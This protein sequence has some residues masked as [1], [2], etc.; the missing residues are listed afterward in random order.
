MT[1]RFQLG[2]VLRQHE[3][4]DGVRQDTHVFGILK[5]EFYRRYKTIFR[6]PT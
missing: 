4:Y 2:G 6:L 1:F 3:L 5:P